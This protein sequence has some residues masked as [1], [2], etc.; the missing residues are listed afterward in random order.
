MNIRI[1]E[2]KLRLR[3][4]LNELTTFLA[5]GR[6]QLKMGFGSAVEKQLGF[7]L[8]LADQFE[9]KSE[10]KED[11]LVISIL[12]PQ[13]E[14]RE[15]FEVAAYPAA[16]KKLVRSFKCPVSG[17]HDLHQVDFELDAFSLKDKTQGA[18]KEL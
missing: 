8:Q 6:A 16:K 11:G 7:H 5:S 14:V 10:N 2:Q 1:E 18:E 13:K 15:L 3:M 17:D 4:E 9:L 12:L